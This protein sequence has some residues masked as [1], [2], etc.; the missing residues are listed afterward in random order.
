LRLGCSSRAQPLAQQ[1]LGS[2]GG[3]DDDD[4]DDDD[5]DGD[6][7]DYGNTNQY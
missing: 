1:T 7:D 6:V 4:I 2:D 3:D 5:I